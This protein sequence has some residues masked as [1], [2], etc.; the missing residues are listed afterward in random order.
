MRNRYYQNNIMGMLD[1]HMALFESHKKYQCDEGSGV[2]ITFY[3]K[4][5]VT[6]KRLQV[7]PT[8][9]W[10]RKKPHHKP[11]ECNIKGKLQLTYQVGRRS[12]KGTQSSSSRS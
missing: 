8:S 1:G 7:N 10:E 6:P 3:L 4:A 12:N 2:D 5:T 11:Q 9:K